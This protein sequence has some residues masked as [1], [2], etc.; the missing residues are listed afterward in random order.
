M[1]CTIIK[2]FF[3]GVV[4]CFPCAL[5]AKTTATHEYRLKN[6]LKLIVKEDHRA[7]VVISQ[8]W[9]KV[10]SSYEPGGITGISH[11]LEHMM[12]RGTKHLGP[13]ELSRLVAS[14]GGQENA[15]TSYDYTA[16]YQKF[17]ADKLP[18]SFKLEA[19]R[20]RHLL[21]DK[22]AF[23]KELQVVMEERRMRTEDNPQAKTYERFLAA[24]HMSSPYHHPVIGWMD[25]IKHMEVGDLRRWYQTWYVPNNA[26]LVVV[27]DVKPQQVYQEAVKHFGQ[28]QKHAVPR[29]KPRREIEPLGTREISVAAPATLP[30]IVMGYNVP[31]L[32]TAKTPWEPYALEVLSALLSGGRSSRIQ[33]HLVRQQKVASDA[34]AGYAL[35]NRQDG[36]FTLEGVPA[37]GKT[38]AMLRQA[39]VGELQQLKEAPVEQQELEKIKNKMVADKVY[40]Q[41]S[42]DFQATEI[43]S[44]EAIGLSWRDASDYVKRVQAVTPQQV[45]EVAKKYLAED[46]LTVAVLKPLPMDAEARQRMVASRKGGDHVR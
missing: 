5:L 30:W 13:G 43:G 3:A 6:G 1:R 38:V 39:M 41:D 23:E 21:L 42:I 31:A 16:Y 14:N 11:A 44:A 2:C 29:L 40:Q 22:K 4:L 36:L 33:K 26:V 37:K 15:F 34:S 28:I 12:F 17:P 18:I 27:G 20:M 32:T 35:Y 46:R 24:A 45:Q 9:Y 10:G 19:D 25:D 7:P 8:I